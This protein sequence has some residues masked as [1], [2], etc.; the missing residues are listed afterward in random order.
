MTTADDRG[1]VVS[2]QDWH[3]AIRC[4][5]LKAAGFKTFQQRN[6]K[7]NV[8]QTAELAIQLSVGEVN[9]VVNIEAAVA[10]LQILPKGALRMRWINAKFP[11]FPF[12]SAT[13]MPCQNSSAGATFIPGAANSTKLTNSPV[14]TVN[15]T[16]IAETTTCWTA[17]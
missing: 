6:L 7:L 2:S 13:C 15:G 11:N 10:Q 8:G 12:L 5:S 1:Q 3:Q 17:R 14:V 9:E 4:S 16:G